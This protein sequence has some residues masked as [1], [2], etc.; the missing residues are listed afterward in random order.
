M[1][2][3]LGAALAVTCLLACSHKPW[4]TEPKLTADQPCLGAKIESDTALVHYAG[5][6]EIRGDFAVAGVTSL[7]SM[8]GLRH[9]TGKLTVARN[10]ELEDLTGLEELHDVGSLELVDN[11]RLDDVIALAALQ[12]AHSVAV[13]GNPQLVDL[14]GLDGVHELDQLVLARNGLRYLKGLENL[15]RV[16]SL[17]ISGNAKLIGIGALNGVEKVRRL[18]IEKNPRLCAFFGLLRGLTEGPDSAAVGENRG[19]SA[20]ETAGLGRTRQSEVASR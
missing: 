7:R 6:T 3:E 11:R 4:L 15:R 14:R 12:S 9:V 20:S 17:V 13:V 19:L 5:C 2:K 10:S 8:R 16:N 1:W 18:V